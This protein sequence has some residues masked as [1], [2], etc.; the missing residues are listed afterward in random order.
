MWG[1]ESHIPSLEADTPS[2][3]Q[4]SAVWEWRETEEIILPSA[5]E[6]LLLTDY[7]WNPENGELQSEYQRFQDFL[8][9]FPE[10]APECIAIL[11]RENPEKIADYSYE[12]GFVIN[13]DT[14]L[15]FFQYF[16]VDL[17][18]EQA[19]DT[20]QQ[21]AIEA[22]KANETLS[23]AEKKQ[24]AEKFKEL[25][26]WIQG[27]NLQISQID[28]ILDQIDAGG[29]MD[30]IIVN[31]EVFFQSLESNDASFDKVAQSFDAQSPESY[32]EYKSFALKQ[33]PNLAPQFE[34][35]EQF[36]T[37]NSP[38]PES[39][40]HR[41]QIAAGLENNPLAAQKYGQFFEIQEGDGITVI[42]VGVEPPKREVGIAGSP[43]RLERNVPVGDFYSAVS[44]EW[45]A[46]ESFS[47]ENGDMIASLGAIEANTN[48]ILTSLESDSQI[49]WAEELGFGDISGIETQDITDIKSEIEE[50]LGLPDGITLDSLAQK[51]WK[52]LTSRSD[53][54]DFVRSSELGSSLQALKDEQE[55]KRLAY[56]RALRK[57]SHSVAQSLEQGDTIARD[58]IQSFHAVGIDIAW[59]EI[60]LILA[61]PRVMSYM[62]SQIPWFSRNHID[63]PNGK[64]GQSGMEENSL[65][66]FRNNIQ[67]FANIMYFWEANPEN[68]GVMS[69][70][71][72]WKYSLWDVPWMTSE[73]QSL[74]ESSGFLNAG[75]VNIPLLQQRLMWKR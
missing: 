52:T 9:Q 51:L 15:A 39:E 54:A 11:S 53:I 41:A 36:R 13:K 19:N 62:E 59:D 25:F 66:V 58:V 69:S 37:T 20:A 3:E 14:C 48:A 40:L 12:N 67:S 30:S 61:D 2:I 1:V 45:L 60:Q 68:G 71:N 7:N 74:R 27:R 16:W 28:S 33:N 18:V 17:T 31:I 21:Q 8:K 35:Y 75:A 46:Y 56:S 29:N 24:K 44:D 23:E 55:T 26:K 22:E 4:V 73:I 64:F 70:V 34:R 49:Q 42:N 47:R 6:E 38:T 5:V 43:M 50:S 72:F 57:K 10:Y 65:T 63:L 32:A